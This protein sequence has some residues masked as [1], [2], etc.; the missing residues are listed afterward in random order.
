MQFK[1]G[2]EVAEIL[3]ISYTKLLRLVYKERIKEP[4][5]YGMMYLWSDADI[6][7]ARRAIEEEKRPS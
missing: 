7:A 6:D 1:Q 4:L 3:G 5:R 2:K